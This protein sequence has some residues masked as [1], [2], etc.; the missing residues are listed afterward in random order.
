M[1]PLRA[2]SGQPRGSGNRLEAG[3]TKKLGA[4]LPQD[5]FEPTLTDAATQRAA[6]YFSLYSLPALWL[7]S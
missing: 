6:G 7:A 2:G 1:G 4:A 3:Q 5:S